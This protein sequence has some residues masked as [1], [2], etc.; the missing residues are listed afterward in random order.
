MG[1]FSDLPKDVIWLI[2]R[3]TII[4][5]RMDW[6]LANDGCVR[7][8]WTPQEFEQKVFRF[9]PIG[10][11]WPNYAQ[12]FCNMASIN[13][14]CLNIIRSKTRKLSPD[15]FCLVTGSFTN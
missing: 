10:S 15:G 14:E 12:F 2:L 9:H 13:R 7:F 6:I 11:S 1:R 5:I 4:Y 8:M 3:Q